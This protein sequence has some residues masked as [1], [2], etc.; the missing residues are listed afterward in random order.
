MMPSFKAWL[1]GASPRRQ[2]VAHS[3]TH[4]F[5]HS[6][7]SSARDVTSSR[8][9]SA[10]THALAY[11][12]VGSE[13]ES[14]AESDAASG[15]A[16][17]GGAAARTTRTRTRTSS[18]TLGRTKLAYVERAFAS[19]AS[20]ATGDGYEEMSTLAFTESEYREACAERGRI[21]RCAW[22]P[23]REA[24]ARAAGGKRYD[25][26]GSARVV[27][28][29]AFVGSF[30]CKE[31]VLAAEALAKRLG[32]NGRAM[33]A[34]EGAATKPAAARLA[35]R[36]VKDEVLER[37][38]VEIKERT[39]TTSADDKPQG[40]PMSAVDARLAASAVEGYVPRAARRDAENEKKKKKTATT[41]KITWN[42]E[43]LANIERENEEKKEAAAADPNV[44][45]GV[46]YFDTFGE[47]KKPDKE[48][49]PSIGG[50]FAEGQLRTDPRPVVDEESVLKAMETLEIEAKASA[51]AGGD[52]G[53]EKEKDVE[54]DPA[55]S[56]REALAS[57][58][59]AKPIPGFFDDD[60]DDDD[61]DDENGTMTSHSDDDDVSTSM[62]TIS[63]FG[64]TWMAV[65]NLVTEATFALVAGDGSFVD[66]LPPRD[67]YSV[68]VSEAWNETLASKAVPS[69]CSTLKISSERR[70]IEQN[71]TTLLRTFAF[72]RAVPA[73]TNERWIMLG[74]LFV[75]LL[76]DADLMSKETIGKEVLDNAEAVA[77]Y[78]SADAT[79]EEVDL[80]RQRLRGG[81]VR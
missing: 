66:K 25:V 44:A 55:Q 36:A 42:E 11:G 62:P 60:D 57:T 14:D 53:V 71:L 5:I 31:H 68:S 29:G 43:E 56:T 70:R 7:H 6:F 52:E 49:V 74:L 2:A 59:T 72:D 22:L 80:L 79:S 54:E 81:G 28:D 65:D 33:S 12:D 78:A 50:R 61:D 23:C 4:S 48:Y 27:R 19:E 73:F 17:D 39:T 37:E 18:G 1:L 26:D 3:F 34:K 13:S 16:S 46:F 47:G 77:I 64:L 51:S 40:A 69:L 45:T 32:K 30:C 58:L 63:Q 41:T 8:V 24:S 21:G 38:V 35:R 75:E 76:L 67:K 10:G 9:M 15:R 20:E